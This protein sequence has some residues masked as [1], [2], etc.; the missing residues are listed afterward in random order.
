M[1]L[2]APVVDPFLPKVHAETG[3]LYGYELVTLAT[4]FTDFRYPHGCFWSRLLGVRRAWAL[5]QEKPGLQ[6]A[7]AGSA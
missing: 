4:G 3:M 2:R 5:E 6:P 1:P 7:L